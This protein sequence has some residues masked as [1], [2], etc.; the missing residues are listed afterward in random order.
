M[1]G[2]ASGC[3]RSWT[4]S[5]TARHATAPPCMRASSS[6]HAENSN[7]PDGLRSPPHTAGARRGAETDEPGVRSTQAVLDLVTAA[8]PFSLLALGLFIFPNHQPMWST[9]VD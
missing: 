2:P 7:R 9:S 5:M 4:I 6:L 1:P 8:L 3:R